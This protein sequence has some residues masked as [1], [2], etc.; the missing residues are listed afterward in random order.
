MIA[1]VIGAHA[2][3]AGIPR[4]SSWVWLVDAADAQARMGLQA[5]VEC[6]F[7][8]ARETGKQLSRKL[9][10]RAHGIWGEMVTDPEM[11]AQL[12]AMPNQTTSAPATLH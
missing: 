1:N 7:D 9:L 4:K 3:I 10:V 12:D 5:L 2:V 6:R 11:L 8:D